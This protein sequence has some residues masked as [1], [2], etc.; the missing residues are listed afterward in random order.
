MHFI[1]QEQHC[2]ELTKLSKKLFKW[3]F[4]RN[5]ISLLK[6]KS[7]SS[8]WLLPDAGLSV[9]FFHVHAF[10]MHTRRAFE[11]EIVS[12]YCTGSV[13]S[14]LYRLHYNI[15]NCQW[16]LLVFL[17]FGLVSMSCRFVTRQTASHVYN[18]WTVDFSCRQF[19]RLFFS[20]TESPQD[21]IPIF[22]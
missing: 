3:I 14:V 11:P 20:S 10:K 1:F 22:L 17:I 19:V 5:L 21:C 12:I 8:E 6:S 16:I 2:E 7:H 13:P 15:F 18:R 9:P 4:Q